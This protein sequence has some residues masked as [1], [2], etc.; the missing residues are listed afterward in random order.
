MSGLTASSLV[1][2]LSP[3]L[4]FG[5]T[6]LSNTLKNDYT[7]TDLIDHSLTVGRDIRNSVPDFYL[8][9]QEEGG[10]VAFSRD[11]L[12]AVG[13]GETVE[14]AMADLEEAIKLLKEV[15]DEDQASQQKK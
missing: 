7:R 4:S 9:L 6:S 8:E 12:G 1:S 13:Q 3:C 5:D 14:E 15:A 11:Y 10:F 2:D